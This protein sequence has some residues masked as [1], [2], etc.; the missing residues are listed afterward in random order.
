TVGGG[1]I[2]DPRPRRASDPE[3]LATLERGDPAE[4]ARACAREPVTRDEI[5]RTGLLEPTELDGAV[6]DLVQAGDL[7]ATQEWVERKRAE[8]H[9]LLSAHARNAP[10]DPGLPE[11]AVLPTRLAA[12]PP[13]LGIERRGGKAYLPGARAALGEQSSAAE[14]LEAQLA[15]AGPQGIRIED[16]ELAR[17]LETEDSLV[18]L[19]D[20]HA[21]S[22]AAYEAARETLVAE[23]ERE[24]RITLARFRD[25]LGVSRRPAQL[26]LER[27]DADGITRR[28]GDERILRRAALR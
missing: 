7:L 25:L 28:V 16:D 6:H 21:V 13:L 15:E 8:T 9:A 10:L 24:G 20:G 17:Y 4:I 12:F 27:F 3:W 14:T 18:R 2:L 11:A 26:L 5:A 23:C 1:R 19:R 22:T